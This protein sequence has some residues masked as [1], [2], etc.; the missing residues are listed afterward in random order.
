MSLNSRSKSVDC[1]VTTRSRAEVTDSSTNSTSITCG[2]TPVDYLRFK[3][4][5]QLTRSLSAM[6][7]LDNRFK[8]EYIP[9]HKLTDWY[10]SHGQVHR[11][12]MLVYSQASTQL[13]KNFMSVHRSSAVERLVPTDTRPQELT[14]ANSR[15]RFRL[16][17]VKEFT[18][19]DS[20]NRDSEQPRRYEHCYE[21]QT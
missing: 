6:L 20:G 12:L 18:T 5:S 21:K 2:W 7:M 11:V 8:F 3:K 16:N 13:Q 4:T 10:F 19:N 14:C 15:Y 1:E 17:A 9:N